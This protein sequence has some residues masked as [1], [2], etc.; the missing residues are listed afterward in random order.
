MDLQTKGLILSSSP[1]AHLTEISV[2]LGITGNQLRCSRSKEPMEGGGGE[3]LMTDMLF[4]KPGYHHH[5]VKMFYTS[6]KIILN[7]TSVH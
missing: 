4:L 3:L 1:V 2:L 6:S 5:L 7:V